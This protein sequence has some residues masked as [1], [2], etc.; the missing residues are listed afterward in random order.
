MGNPLHDNRLLGYSPSLQITEAG[1][2]PSEAHP[3]IKRSRFTLSTARR[4][5]AGL[6]AASFYVDRELTR[7]F[8]AGDVLHLVR[9]PCA[10]LGL[11]LLRNGK[12]VLAVGAIN[13]V[14]LGDNIQASTPH[15]AFSMLRVVPV[16]VAIRP[17]L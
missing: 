9:T 5:N 3:A 6:S 13:A 11:S 4:L 8:N 10:G 14:P 17:L 1:P 16:H 2:V 15:K 7:A 12:L